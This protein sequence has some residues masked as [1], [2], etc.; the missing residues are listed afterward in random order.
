MRT[1]RMCRFFD[2]VFENLCEII[3]AELATLTPL[4]ATKSPLFGGC[5]RKLV[6][7]HHVNFG[8][9]RRS[10]VVDVL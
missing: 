2:T 4:Q 7:K 1:K 5:L 10:H 3:V 8:H 9:H 6:A